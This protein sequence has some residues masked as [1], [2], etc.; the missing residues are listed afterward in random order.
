MNFPSPTNPYARKPKQPSNANTTTLIC[1]AFT[2]RSLP[3]RVASHSAPVVAF[4]LRNHLDKYIMRKT[5]LKTGQSQGIQ[6]LFMPY[7]KQRATIHIVPLISNISDASLSPRSHQ[8]S[9][10]L[11]IR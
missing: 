11:P 8:G 10:L 5:W 6:I 9:D 1:D 4:D 2:L 7:I 3:N